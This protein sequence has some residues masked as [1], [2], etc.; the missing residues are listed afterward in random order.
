M[1]KLAA[2]QYIRHRV[3]SHVNVRVQRYV[4]RVLAVFDKRFRRI[5]PNSKL[6]RI[7][8]V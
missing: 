2:I 4:Y 5:V 3:I 8:I 6:T 1:S 7:I